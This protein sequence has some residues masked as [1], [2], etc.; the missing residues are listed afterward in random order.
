MK[1]KTIVLMI[2]VTA[3]TMLR[4]S[5]AWT[6]D[7]DTEF[8]IKDD[9]T[10][11]GKHGTI[12]DPDVEILGY[13]RIGTTTVSPSTATAAPG[14]IFIIGKVEISSDT[15][16]KQAFSVDGNAWLQ[17]N[18]YINQ[19]KLNVSGGSVGQVLKKNAAGYLEWANDAGEVAGSAIANYLPLWKND[20]QLTNSKVRQA[21]VSGSTHVYVDAN[22]HLS[23]NV[24]FGNNTNISTFTENGGLR[25]YNGYTPS[26]DYD[27][28]TKKYVDNNIAN[29]GP[30]LRTAPNVYLNN[31]A[32][33]VGIGLTNPSAKLH[34]SSTN[35]QA[36]DYLFIITGGTANRFIVKGDGTTDVAGDFNIN[37]DKFKVTATNGNTSIGGTLSVTGAATLENQLTVKGKSQFGDNASTDQVSINCDAD[38]N[39]ALT[40]KGEDATGKY[41]A[42]FYSG[43]KKAAWIRRK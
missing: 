14:N 41:S 8:G 17:N 25:L 31:G 21:E 33:F 13:I 2:L 28:V 24:Y 30:W 32:D 7:N 11:L 22:I 15:Y 27:V 43:S 19:N 35:A 18:V 12:A 5:L 36:S 1:S 16:V 26:D 40:V 10:V 4:V 9:L 42:V 23:S 38:A 37:I 3:M 34:V 29:G 20:T 6:Q 39:T